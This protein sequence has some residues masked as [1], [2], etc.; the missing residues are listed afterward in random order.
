LSKVIL[1]PEILRAEGALADVDG[2]V[3]CRIIAPDMA[4]TVITDI[5]IVGVITELSLRRSSPKG[6]RL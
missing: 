1:S 2:S 6:W 3:H 4:I 5:T